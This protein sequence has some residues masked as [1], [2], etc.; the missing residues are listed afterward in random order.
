MDSLSAASIRE[1]TEAFARAR[2][3]TKA[4]REAR[5]PPADDWKAFIAGTFSAYMRPPYAAYHET[6]FEFIWSITPTHSPPPFVAIWPRGGAKSTCLE[7]ACATIAALKKRKY[8]LFVSATQD[9]ANDHVDNVAALLEDPEF[10]KNFPAAGRRKLG[11]YGA[12]KAWRIGRIR[13]SDGFTCHAIGLDTAARGAKIEGFRPDVIFMDDIDE[14]LDSP[15][16][17]QKKIETLTKSILP[18]GNENPVIVFVQNLILANGVA[19]RLVEGTADFMMDATISGPHPAVDGLIIEDKPDPADGKIKPT[20]VSGVSTWPARTIERLQVELRRIGRSA[21]LAELQHLVQNLSKGIFA[22]VEFQHVFPDQVPQLREIIVAVDPAVTDTDLSDSHGIQ[23]DGI[24]DGGDLYRLYS[25]EARTSPEDSL[26]RAIRIARDLGASKIIIETDQ[27]GDTWD[28]VFELAWLKA[29]SD[30]EIG[31]NES[32]LPMEQVKAGGRGSKLHRASLMLAAYERGTVY[33]VIQPDGS[34]TVLEK[35]LRRFGVEKPFDLVD[36]GYYSW[37]GLANPAES[38]GGSIDYTQKRE[39]SLSRR[40]WA[41][42]E[43]D[44]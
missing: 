23:A 8:V 10:A 31:H 42:R 17:T 37:D 33:H 29:V 7:V 30:G 39:Q 34:S 26:R 15:L 36:A 3:R 11:K 12:S 27:G 28:S 43:T 1:V 20:I 40:L 32:M 5:K 19:G 25:W 4:A 6:F 2:I 9:Q 41:K 24:T 22:K 44:Q 13:T 35:A 21:F 38:T 14:L 16:T 18:T